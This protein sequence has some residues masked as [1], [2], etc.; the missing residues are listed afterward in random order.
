MVQEAAGAHA[1]VNH[2]DARIGVVPHPGQGDLV[3]GGFIR[4]SGRITPLDLKR[5]LEDGMPV[6][7][8]LLTGIGH[9]NAADQAVFNSLPSRFR[10]KDASNAMGQSSGSN[11]VRFLSKCCSLAILRKEGREYEKVAPALE[12]MEGLE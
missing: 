8:Q 6:G 4:G 10:F 7:Y 12:R 2:S 5:V 3:L 1:L 9:L 11:V